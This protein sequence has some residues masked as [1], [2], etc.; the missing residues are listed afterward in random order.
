MDPIAKLKIDCEN[1][2]KRAIESRGFTLQNVIE[3]ANARD[4]RPLELQA[5]IALSIREVVAF[6]S[7]QKIM[8]D[9]VNGIEN[10]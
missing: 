7:Q 2:F 5:A 6:A 3:T 8:K 9:I 1:V 10:N 4:D